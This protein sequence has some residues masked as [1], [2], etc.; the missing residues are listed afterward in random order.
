[1]DTRYNAESYRPVRCTYPYPG[2]YV[3]IKFLGVFQLIKDLEN[4][5]QQFCFK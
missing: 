1:M 3:Q 2:G 5:L 4:V